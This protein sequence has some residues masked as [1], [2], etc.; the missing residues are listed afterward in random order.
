MDWKTFYR[1]SR[2]SLCSLALF[3]LR[4]VEL[5]HPRTVFELV[6]I[7]QHWI[8]ELSVHPHPVDEFEPTMGQATQG[9]GVTVTFI[10]MV[11]VVNFGP[12][13]PGQGML[14]K[15]LVQISDRCMFSG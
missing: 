8:V 10:A 2:G 4:G 6:L 1:F 9:I 12:R 13:T 11:A 15:V 3:R 5:Q 7:V 14:G